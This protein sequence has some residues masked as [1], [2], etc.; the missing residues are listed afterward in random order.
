MLGLMQ[1]P[2]PPIG[3]K[4][5]IHS[6]NI[7]GQPGGIAFGKP[8]AP[9]SV[10]A[11]AM[12]TPPPSVQAPAMPTPPPS[13]QAPVAPNTTQIPNQ[14]TQ[15]SVQ[16]SPPSVAN[17]VKTPDP[18]IGVMQMPQQQ[19]FGAKQEM[20]DWWRNYISTGQTDGLGMSPFQGQYKF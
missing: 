14:T 3:H 11:P 4:G 5:P 13:V 18:S 16:A 8:P 7:P 20:P 10:Q 15:P 12:P 19:Q 6:Y 1:A 9:P 17:T 2:R